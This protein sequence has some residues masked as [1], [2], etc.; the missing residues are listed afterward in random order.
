MGRVSEAFA[1]FALKYKDYDALPPEVVH[2]TK[3]I[4]LNSLGIAV[5]GLASDK[6]KIGVQ[7]A[8]I[9]G[10]TPESTLLGVGGKFSAPVAAFANAELLN[11]LDMDALPHIPPIVIPA[12]LASAEASGSSGKELIAAMAVGQEIA[13]R[14]SRIFLAVMTSSIAKYGKT[15]DIF[16]N[17][18]EHIIG[19]A[20]G[21]GVA[22]GLNREQLQQAIGIAAYYCSLPVCRDWESTIPKSMIKYVPVSWIAQGAVQA[23]QIAKLG[24]TGNKDTFDNPLGYPAIYSREDVWDEEKVLERL[25]E[26]WYSTTYHY[27]PYP[28]CRFLHS[29]LDCFYRLMNKYHFS[30][31]EIEAVECHSSAFVAH[32]DQYAVENQVDAQF[33]GPYCIALAAHKYKPG[34]AWQDK[35][36]LSDPAVREFMKKVTMHIDPHYAELRKTDMNTWY[37]RV[38]IKARG[39]TFVEETNYS[40]GTNV[41]GYRLTEEELKTMF[42]TCASV[43]LPDDK[44]ERAIHRILHLEEEPDLKGLMADLSL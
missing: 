36:A 7:L 2:E 20:V 29:D 21:S 41:E 38:E 32:P 14:L 27:K 28:C 31:E 8:R 30:P 5:G 43:V 25:G 19:A 18:N 42:R 13:K 35:A 44:I 22:M 39:E 15:P 4:L 6:G 3:R 17:S 1:D 11:G 16:G 33:S 12:I 37:A 10:G 26:V 23:A 24:Y 40:W 34:P 9:Q